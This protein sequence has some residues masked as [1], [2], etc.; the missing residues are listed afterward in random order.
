MPRASPAW[1]PIIEKYASKGK[2]VTLV[3]MNDHSAQR[4]AHIS[5]LLAGAH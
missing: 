2:T 5:E 1:T 4:H 3:G